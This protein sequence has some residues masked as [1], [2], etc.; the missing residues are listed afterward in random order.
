MICR[1]TAL[2]MGH[3]IRIYNPVTRRLP[4]RFYAT[5]SQPPSKHVRNS[6]GMLDLS[7][8]ITFYREFGRPLAKVVI[9]ALA[10]FEALKYTSLALL[11]D[12]EL[13][14]DGSGPSEETPTS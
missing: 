13:T 12:G 5:Q 6:D 8:K 7:N 14:D 11:K 9:I 1:Q 10:T 2:K 3:T 4:F